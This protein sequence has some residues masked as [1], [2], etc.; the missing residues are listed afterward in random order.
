MAVTRDKAT[1]DAYNRAS[2]A[3]FDNV[4]SSSQ[5]GG[6]GLTTKDREPTVVEQASFTLYSVAGHRNRLTY[7]MG[8]LRGVTPESDTTGRTIHDEPSVL[9]RLDHANRS[10]Q[11]D[12]D[13]INNLLAELEDLLCRG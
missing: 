7:I 6:I 4:A 13:S 9:E 11:G 8:R 3:A 12:L 10:A 2:T 5:I 1:R